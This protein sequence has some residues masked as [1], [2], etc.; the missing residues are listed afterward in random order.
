MISEFEE[1]W[2]NQ[3]IK[4]CFLSLLWS[5]FETS[6]DTHVCQIL[7]KGILLV[8]KLYAVAFS[9]MSHVKSLQILSEN[10]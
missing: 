2:G 8:S 4:F 7:I 6:G 1:K 5:K 10:T 3:K 9:Q